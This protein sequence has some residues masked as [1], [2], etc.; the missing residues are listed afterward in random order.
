MCKQCSKMIHTAKQASQ[1]LIMPVLCSYSY[2]IY[3]VSYVTSLF[4]S[5]FGIL[6]Q[7]YTLTGGTMGLK[8][9][10][11]A[12]YNY[13]CT[14]LNQMLP[15]WP[16]RVDIVLVLKSKSKQCQVQIA[17][18]VMCCLIC[19]L[20]NL[21]LN[22]SLTTFPWKIRHSSFIREGGK[23]LDLSISTSQI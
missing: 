1:V 8:D 5:K 11:L 21:V 4:C 2:I 3:A 6:S 16:A 14:W 17:M 20:T 9:Y 10:F 12:S 18:H 15:Q 19:L 22:S 13:R 7:L 23:V